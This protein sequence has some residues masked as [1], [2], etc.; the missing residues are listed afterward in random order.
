VADVPL[1]SP[2]QHAALADDSRLAW[3]VEIVLEAARRAPVRFPTLAYLAKTV[4]ASPR[5]LERRFC[6]A[7]GLSYRSF[8]QELR[9]RIAERRLA[10]RDAVE[11]SVARDVGYSSAS[12]LARSFAQIRSVTPRGRRARGKT[13]RKP[14]TGSP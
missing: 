8:K 2:D 3:V 6:R 4:H 1:L 9:V 7:L 10:D 12:T 11:K 5:T 13:R 14:R